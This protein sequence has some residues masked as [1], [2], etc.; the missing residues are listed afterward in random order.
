[1]LT[2]QEKNGDGCLSVLRKYAEVLFAGFMIHSEK[3]AIFLL[4][5]LHKKITTLYRSTKTAGM[6]FKHI[7]NNVDHQEKRDKEKEEK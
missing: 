2:K 6:N 7:N 4:F 3:R 1:M 5:Y